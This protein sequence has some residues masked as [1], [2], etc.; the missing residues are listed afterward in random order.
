MRESNVVCSVM[1]VLRV[2][3]A[4]RATQLCA[5]RHEFDTALGQIYHPRAMGQRAAIYIYPFC[6]LMLIL[7]VACDRAPSAPSP[8]SSS[9]TTRSV[10]VAS[11]S[12]A[13]T[14]I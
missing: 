14:E 10:T 11:L 3:A 13:A 8:T 2:L 6:P 4:H 9:A 12:P 5:D 7:A 1:C